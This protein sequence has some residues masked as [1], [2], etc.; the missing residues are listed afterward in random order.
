MCKSTSH[1]SITAL[2]DADSN[3]ILSMDIP[4]VMLYSLESTDCKVTGDFIVMLDGEEASYV[5]TPTEIGH[6]VTVEF[7]KD[8]HEIEII[9]TTIIPDPSPAQ[10]CGIVEGYEKQFLAPLDQTDRGVKPEFIRCNAGLVLIQKIDDSPACVKP[11]TKIKLIERGWIRNEKIPEQDKIITPEDNDKLIDIKKG[12]SFVVKL[13][14]SYDWR[15]D[16]NNK[17]VV[18]SDYSDIRYSGSQGVYRAHNSGQAILTGIGDPLCRL[19]EPQCAS[20]SILFQ[21]NI[22]VN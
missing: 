12:E 19:S 6:L 20:P 7:T 9:G 14:S 10:Y 8:F 22:N 18:D 5:I 4:L 15:I 3:G 2:I 11:E 17:T 21:L 13:D 16:I 1:N